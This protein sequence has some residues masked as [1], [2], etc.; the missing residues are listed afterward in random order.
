MPDAVTDHKA[1]VTGF[2]S[3]AFVRF[4]TCLRSDELRPVDAGVWVLRAQHFVTE[5]PSAGSLQWGRYLWMHNGVVGGFMAI[6]RAML[7]ALSDAAYNTVQ[8]QD[9]L[10]PLYSC[11]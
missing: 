7:A 5:Q 2:D 6:R 8:V 11:D 10:L 4:M 3:T 1:R 9:T